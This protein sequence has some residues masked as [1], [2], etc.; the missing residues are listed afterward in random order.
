MEVQYI[1]VW[2]AHPVLNKIF[3]TTKFGK[4][5]YAVKQNAKRMADHFDSILE[6]VRSDKLD[7]KWEGD[8]IPFEDKAFLERFEE[9]LLNERGT[10]DPYYFPE[11]WMQHAD[12]INGFDEINV[13]WLF[14][15]NKPKPEDPKA[16][17]EE[18]VEA[19]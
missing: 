6:W 1:R 12:D 4:L 8:N 16:E 2:Q 10:F 7:H 9:Y 17:V 3:G 19:E 15:E 18:D 11:E 13:A 5:R 14:E